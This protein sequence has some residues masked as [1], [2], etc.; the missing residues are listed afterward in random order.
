MAPLT[1][2]LRS[3]PAENVERHLRANEL[4]FPTVLDEDG[5][6]GARWGVRGVPT[7]FVIAPDG[8]IDHVSVGYSTWLGLRLRLW[9]A[10]FTGLG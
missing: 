7:T 2:A 6:L 9:L 8:T 1:V 10:R 4:N 5:L 3:G